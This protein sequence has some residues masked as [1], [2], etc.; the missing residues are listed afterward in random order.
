MCINM[1][2]QVVSCMTTLSFFFF[3]FFFFFTESGYTTSFIKKQKSLIDTT[4][5]Y[6]SI[7]GSKN[8][9]IPQQIS[10]F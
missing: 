6:L 9:K 8:L 4:A 5:R 1:A 3:F 10:Y 2:S 7:D